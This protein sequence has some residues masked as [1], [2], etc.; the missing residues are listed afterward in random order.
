LLQEKEIVKIGGN[1]TIPL[2]I[3]IIAATNRDLSEMV[4]QK[5]F[6]KDLFYRLSVVPVKIPSLRERKEDIAPLIAYYMKYYNEKYGMSRKLDRKT[7]KCLLNYSWPGNIRELQNLLEYMI[8][9]A[10]SDDIM[11]DDLPNEILRSV[12]KGDAE[13]FV[14]AGGS[15][16]SAL[17]KAEKYLLVEAMRKTRNTEE[18]AEI[19]NVDR[20]TIIRKMKKHGLKS[21]F[22]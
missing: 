11:Q 21:H 18:M 6:R 1:K 20:S 5:Q 12:G 15:L 4:K 9:T 13:A 22:S 7:M 3:R 8:V 10:G 14:T 17:D 16:K 19:L 2:D